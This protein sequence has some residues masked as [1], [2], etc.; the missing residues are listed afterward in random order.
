MDRA[1][2]RKQAKAEYKKLMKSTPKSRR[3]PFSQAFPM[4]KTMIE[5]GLDGSESLQDTP[6]ETVSADD[7]NLISGMMEE[8]A[9][10]PEVV[11]VPLAGQPIEEIKE[12]SF[13]I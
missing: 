7:A 12:A 11:D 10:I 5:N 13:G 2:L 8:P 1:I 3:V 4:L 6:A 9:V